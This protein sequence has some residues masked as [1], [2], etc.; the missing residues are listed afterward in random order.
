MGYGALSR[1]VLCLLAPVFF[2]NKNKSLSGERDFFSCEREFLLGRKRARIQRGER[3]RQT[4]QEI[5]RERQT[6]SGCM[7]VY[8]CVCLSVC[9]CV[10]VCVCVCVCVWLVYTCVYVCACV[11][12]CERKRVTEK[13]IERKG[14]S[15]GERENEVDLYVCVRVHVCVRVCF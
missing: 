4:E 10:Y 1:C 7:C 15:Q 12:L 2:L 9:V 14:E 11:C 13:N 6:R 8:V 3:G 5:V